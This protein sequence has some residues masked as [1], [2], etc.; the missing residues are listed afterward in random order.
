MNEQERKEKQREYNRRYQKKMKLARQ[1]LKQSTKNQIIGIAGILGKETL[2][3]IRSML[4]ASLSNPLMGIVSAI[5]IGDILYRSKIIDIQSYTA[6]MV[7]VGVLEGTAVASSVINDVSDFFKIFQSQQQSNDPITPTASTVVV[8][9]ESQKDLQS[10][11][12]EM[13]KNAGSNQ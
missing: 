3:V 13:T 8:G 9:S 6:I 11:M 4:Q 2:E 10:L 1:Q 5:T 7:S 12:S